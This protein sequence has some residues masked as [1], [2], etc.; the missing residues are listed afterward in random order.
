MHYRPHQRA[1]TRPLLTARELALAAGALATAAHV[2]LHLAIWYMDRF[3]P[4]RTIEAARRC[5][6]AAS[7]FGM[8]HLLAVALVLEANGLARLDLCDEMEAKLNQ[9]FAVGGDQPDVLGMAWAQCRAMLSLLRE[10]RRHA[11]QQLATSMDYLR[12]LPTT[13]PV[14]TRGLWALLR[15]VQDLEERRRAPTCGP[16]G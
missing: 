12:R 9:A 2:D 7:R 8:R 11:L 4:H 10:N 16:P 5:A 1:I 3:D 6:D 14:P 13:P 15:T